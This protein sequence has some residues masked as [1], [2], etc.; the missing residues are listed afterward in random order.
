MRVVGAS[1]FANSFFDAG[2]IKGK[3]PKLYRNRLEMVK[4]VFE[5][6]SFYGE[7][8]QEVYEWEKLG[9]TFHS[10]KFNI[11]FGEN[12]WCLNTIGSNNFSRRSFERDFE[13]NLILMSN[14]VY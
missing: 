9:W 13:C 2:Y 12:G 1:P 3:I 6:N 8:K 11:N 5:T 10:K 7:I 14:S 4:S